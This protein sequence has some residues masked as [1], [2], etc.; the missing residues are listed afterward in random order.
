MDNNARRSFVSS[1]LFDATAKT[2][3]AASPFPLELQ[4]VIR[5]APSPSGTKL[6]VITTRKD[7]GVGAASGGAG[8]QYLDIWG[9]STLLASV[10]LDKHHDK[11]L[12]D[13]N[14]IGQV[15]AT[16]C[17]LGL[18]THP[19]WLFVRLLAAWFGGLQWSPNED[20]L[21]YTALP[22]PPKRTTFWDADPK[23]KG[24]GDKFKFQEDWYG[25]THHR[26]LL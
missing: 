21:V 5:L 6:A 24:R 8:K 7:K 16:N 2:W 13:G 15:Q 14:S 1:Y 19:R 23:A 25:N 17:A 9:N 18:T 10:C 20:L 12:G 26:P 22:T 3:L 4:G 11:V